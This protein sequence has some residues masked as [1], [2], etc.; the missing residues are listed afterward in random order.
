M[1]ASASVMY[2]SAITADRDLPVSA[3]GQTTEEQAAIAALQKILA[4]PTDK[5]KGILRLVG[6]DMGWM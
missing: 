4:Q 2:Q 1:K 3:T 6:P 5:L